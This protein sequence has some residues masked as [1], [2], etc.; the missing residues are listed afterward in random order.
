MTSL[1]LI[2]SSPSLVPFHLLRDVFRSV[3]EMNPVITQVSKAS[4]AL[5][6]IRF[7]KEPR[8][9]SPANKMPEFNLPKRAELSPVDLINISSVMNYDKLLEVT[10]D[11]GHLPL[12]EELMSMESLQN[13]VC[14]MAARA[15]KLE[16]LKFARAKG[17]SFG[18][19]TCVE[20]AI[21]GQLEVLKWLH[22]QGC[23]WDKMTCSFAAA[24]GNL[25]VLKWLREQ[26]CPWDEDTCSYAARGGHLEVLIWARL[27]ECA[28]DIGFCLYGAKRFRQ[29]KVIEWI[30]THT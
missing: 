30:E 21:G 4:A 24:G 29:D 22:E 25:E 8:R 14:D 7:T 3:P 27:H 13:K 9:G 1:Q 17:Y 28:W 19:F 20:A 6:G 18:E 10:I 12:L 11:K 2:H 15:G 23:P 5:S 16:V 26:G